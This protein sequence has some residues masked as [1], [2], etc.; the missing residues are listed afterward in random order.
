MKILITDGLAKQGLELLKSAEGIEVDERGGVSPE[1]LLEIIG[2]YEG[3]VVRSATEVTAE[4]I[5]A[6]GGSLRVIGRAGV[7]IDNI[8]VEAATKNGVA[9]MNTPESNSITTAEH[10]VTLLLSL[11]RRIPQAHASVRAGKWERN[12]YRGVEVF[13][14]TIGLVGLGHIGKLVAERAKGLRMKAVAYD[15]YLSRDAAKKLGMELVSLD[16]LFSRADVVTVHTP[17]TSETE[18]LI[19]AEAFGKMKEGVIVINCARGGIV[20]EAD[21]AEALRSGKVG[22]AAFDV[23]TTEPVSSENPLVS[24]EDNIVLTPHLGAS[25]EEAQIKV[26]VTMAEQIID[27]ARKGVVRN[28][29]NMPSLTMEQLAAVKPYL[30][31][32]EKMGSLHG[33]LRRGAARRVEIIYEGEAAEME[34][35][36]MTV[37]V[38]K[39]FLGQ[40]MSAPVTYVNAPSVA[41]DRKIEVVESRSRASGRYRNLVTVKVKTREE[42]GSV[43]GSVLGESDG[44]IVNVDG[45]DID[46]VPEGFL[47]VSRNYDRPGFIGSMCSVLGENGIN[48]G[49]MHLG[50]ESVGGQAIVFTNV[51]TEVGDGVIGEI[52]S[53]PHIISVTQ[54]SFPDE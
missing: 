21:M 50:R 7:G 27:F 34:S 35:K 37:A 6:A 16:E 49:R 5:G 52:S 54:V 23:Y 39:G 20:N 2:N 9:V 13:G 1:E 12:R 33:Q 4:V 32:C 28:A 19:D 29:V 41:E 45:V 30:S 15:P 43:S 25:T 36:H 26:G 47:L 10:T 48:I 22:G 46:V 31:I 11:A 18:N 24:V 17:L 14:K 3:L 38:L 42:T 44:R 53:I 8:D 40:I 51:D